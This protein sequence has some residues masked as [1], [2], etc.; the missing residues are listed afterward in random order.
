MYRG[1]ILSFHTLITCYNC[2]RNINHLSVIHV[3]CENVSSDK[4]CE[5]EIK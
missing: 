4:P 5:I 2:I 3:Y 1:E